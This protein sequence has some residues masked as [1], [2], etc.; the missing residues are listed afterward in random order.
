MTWPRVAALALALAL[1][2]FALTFE[3]VWPTLWIVPHAALSVELAALVLLLA[4]AVQRWGPPSRRAMA[5]LAALFVA[6]ALARYAEVTTEALYGRPINLYYDAPYIP[7][8]VA[9]F[10]AAAPLPVVLAAGAGALAL[11]AA[12]YLLFRA[13]L[14][15]LAAALQVS[16]PR[17]ILSVLS[18]AAIASYLLGAS[19]FAT[20]LAKT[21][22][23]QAM[24]LRDALT[25]SATPALGPPP[26][27][28]F[29]LGRLEG[30]DV[31]IVFIESYGATTFDM[32]AYRDAIEASRATLASAIAASGRSVV[33]TLVESPTFGGGSWLAHASL[34]S[35]TE[36]RDGPR[37]NL[38]MT[39]RRDTLVQT[40]ARHGYRTIA[41][42]PGLRQA[43][44][45]GAFYG[46]D[47]IYSAAR[48]D[49]RGPAFGWWRIPDQYALAKLA[50]LELNAESRAP[51][52]VF[53]PT[54]S[55]H[56]PFRPTPPYVA[57]WDKMLSAQ[58][59]AR[60]VAQRA[61]AERAEW[62]NLGPAYAEAIGYTLTSLA[63]FLAHRAHEDSVMV[64]LG[65]H[66]PPAGVSGPEASWYVPVH[67]ITGKPP[68]VDA[69]LAQGFVSGLAPRQPA[70]RRMHELATQLLSAFS[71][72]KHENEGTNAVRLPPRGV[73][74]AL[75]H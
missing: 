27:L 7:H 38:L 36:V 68:I 73:A 54:I 17:K 75:S 47:D 51:L 49:Y 30:A 31:L 5:F 53:F 40:F 18:I 50:R 62:T 45:E 63:G 56:A 74:P 6:L 20:P 71:I 58:P 8:V 72:S 41:L 26:N 28:R 61:L 46:F 2:N 64:V 3:N 69:L 25:G 55:S 14:V 12:L 21:Y 22:A 43:W 16:A 32:P 57:D 35:A 10:A 19:G 70:P 23:Q 44:P 4:L 59:Y 52:F 33:S 67:I 29:D 1:L 65:D 48:L 66:Q 15:P 24:L 9:M 11:L 37:Y 42:M 60:E 39:Q 13:A 34:L